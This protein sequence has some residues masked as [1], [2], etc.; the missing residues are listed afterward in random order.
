M[1]AASSN[2]VGYPELPLAGDGGTQPLPPQ[3]LALL[4]T[5]WSFL[6]AQ[7]CAEI[8][9]HGGAIVGDTLHCG[10]PNYSKSGDLT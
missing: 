7:V 3:S 5:S 9:D 2:L 8:C 6:G 1:S 4:V 10:D